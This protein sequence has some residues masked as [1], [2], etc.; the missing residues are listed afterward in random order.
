MNIVPARKGTRHVRATITF[1]GTSG[2]GLA[3]TV[4]PVFTTVGKVL[5]HYITAFCTTLLDQAA[6]TAQVSLGTTSQVI[7]FVA[8][9]NS[10]DI[11]QNEWWVT[12][13]PTVGSIDTP[14]ACQNVLVSENI[15]INPTTQNTNAGVLVVDCEFEPISDDGAL[16]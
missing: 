6:A 5:V 15:I 10:I 1:D 12:G 4:V 8:A 16:S 2:K 7:R 13:T 9:T 11:D 3:G 14:D